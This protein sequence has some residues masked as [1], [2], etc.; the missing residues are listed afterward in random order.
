MPI[1]WTISPADRLVTARAEGLI[2]LQDIEALLDD[3]V[4][5]NALNYRKMFDGR[6]SSGKYDD[7]DVMALGARISAYNSLGLAGAAAIVVDTPEQHDVALR[8]ANI[9]KGKR[10]IRAFYSP[11]DARAWLDSNPSLDDSV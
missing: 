4:V 5:K 11:D 9:A 3:I 1:T 8:F 2:T 6:G 10:P 7:N